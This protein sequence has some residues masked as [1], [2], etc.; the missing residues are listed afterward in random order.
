MADRPA[1]RAPDLREPALRLNGIKNS[2]I[3]K[4]LG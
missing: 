2:S 4:A 3:A 1:E